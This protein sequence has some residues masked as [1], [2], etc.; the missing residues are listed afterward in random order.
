[1]VLGRVRPDPSGVSFVFAISELDLMFKL[2][3]M[4]LFVPRDSF[5]I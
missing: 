1:M 3:G 5:Y 2:A 4:T